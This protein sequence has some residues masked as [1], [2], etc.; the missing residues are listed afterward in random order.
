MTAPVRIMIGVCTF[1]RPA[2][3]QTLA[4]L[5]AQAAGDLAVEVVVA[6]NDDTPTAAPL[7]AAMRD[8]YPWKL[9]LVHAPAR[10]ISVAR[11]AILDAA[12]A[13]GIRFLAF[14]DDDETAVPGWIAALAAE[15]LRS[16]AAATMGPVIAEYADGAP[17][18]MRRAGVHNCEAIT[19]ARGEIVSGYSGNVLLDLHHPAVAGLRFD[20]ARGVS[21]GEDTAFFAA[22]RAAGGAFAYTPDAPVHEPVP[23]DRATM[24]WLLRRRFRMGQTHGGLLGQDASAL[25]RAGLTGLTLAKMSACLGMSAAGAFNPV[26]RNRQLMRAALHAGAVAGLFRMA[27]LQLY[28]AD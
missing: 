1:R 26:R 27:D 8:G 4:S 15:H 13:A 7:V 16:G 20:P 6:D 21:G 5:A 11:N 10:N 9:T 23:A 28:R 17:D 12:E 3:V 24:T 22:I 2:L 19:S 25:R 14:I 18:W